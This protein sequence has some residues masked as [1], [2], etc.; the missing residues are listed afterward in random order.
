MPLTNLNNHLCNVLVE[1]GGE[2]LE[3]QCSE[4]AEEVAQR[5][6]HSLTQSTASMMRLL[7]KDNHVILVKA[8]KVLAVETVYSHG[9]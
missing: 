3:Y 9:G 8:R 2:P 6:T 4:Q 7:D 5:V 1:T